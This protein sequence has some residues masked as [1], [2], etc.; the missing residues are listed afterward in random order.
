MKNLCSHCPSRSSCITLCKTA[1]IYVNQD[2][3][4]P[5][6]ITVS[7]PILTGT[8]DTWNRLN[9]DKTEVVRQVVIRLTEDKMT[10]KEISYHVPISKRHIRRIKRKYLK[11][12]DLI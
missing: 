9:M 8:E 7:V 10:T 4:S 2:Y 11:K 12:A 3:S 1:E 5:S 6:E